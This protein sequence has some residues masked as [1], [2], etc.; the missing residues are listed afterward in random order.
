MSP[1]DV[2]LLWSPA[3]VLVAIASG[4][5]MAHVI[6]H[7]R[8]AADTRL[9]SY[10]AYVL[11]VLWYGPLIIQRALDGSAPA[12]ADAHTIGTFLLYLACFAT[13]MALTLS[14]HRRRHP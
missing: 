13:P 7:L 12:G 8:P 4:I 14:R 3:S 10:L 2:F 5:A 11:G 9:T 6:I 1:A